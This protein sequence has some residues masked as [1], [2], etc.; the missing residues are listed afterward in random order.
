MLELVVEDLCVGLHAS[1]D[2]NCVEDLVVGFITTLA[3]VA[4][5]R[6]QDEDKTFEPFSH[7]IYKVH[8]ICYQKIELATSLEGLALMMYFTLIYSLIIFSKPKTNSQF[9]IIK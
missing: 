5:C 4:W 9:Y 8:S 2:A 7:S 3:K 6:S 1:F